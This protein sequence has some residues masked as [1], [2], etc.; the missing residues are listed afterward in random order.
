MVRQGIFTVLLGL[1]MLGALP[2]P[3]NALVVPPLGPKGP[4]ASSALPAGKA[5]L[6]PFAHMRFCKAHPGDCKES[7]AAT[8]PTLTAEKWKELRSINVS[9]NG[10]IRPQNDKPGRINDKWTLA[11]K[12]G[13]C[14]DYAVTKRHRLIGRGW[15]QSALALAIAVAP[16]KGHHAVLVV[17]TEAGDYVL[18]NLHNDVRPW[19]S[20]GYRWL[21]VQSAANPRKWRKI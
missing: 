14:E 8:S 10:A 15:P 11:P 9:I 16:G 6:E 21:K 18:D 1:A 13:D 3:V 4:P 17:R 19:R 20:L 2:Q 5:V 7:G 12:A